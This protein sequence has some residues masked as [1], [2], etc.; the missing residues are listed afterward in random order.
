MEYSQKNSRFEPNEEQ[1]YAKILQTQKKDLSMLI[2]VKGICI[3][4]VVA[5]HCGVCIPHNL[6]LMC[7]L[8]FS[9]THCCL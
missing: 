9:H 6:S 2:Y 5:T 4:L 7:F 8:Q 3:T 1:K